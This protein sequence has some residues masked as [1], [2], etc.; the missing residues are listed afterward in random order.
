MGS[1]KCRGKASHKPLLLLCLLDMA[2]G[3]GGAARV[4]P[5][6]SGRDWAAEIAHTGDGLMPKAE[7]AGKRNPKANALSAFGRKSVRNTIQGRNHLLRSE[8][9]GLGAAKHG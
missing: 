5:G 4:V 3:S 7:I 9:S 2:G 1:L 6:D 8:E